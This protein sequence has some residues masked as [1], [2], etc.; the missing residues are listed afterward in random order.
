MV[1]KNKLG[2]SVFSPTGI[3]VVLVSIALMVTS[4][5]ILQRISVF[6]IIFNIPMLLLGI[7]YLMIG[8]ARVQIHWKR[9][10]IMVIGIITAQ[11]AILGILM[12]G[13]AGQ[14]ELMVLSV[15]FA[16]IGVALSIGALTWPA[17]RER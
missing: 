2:Y 4:I 17:K 16:F 10:S 13:M 9:I 6:W 12:W 7:A 11:V 14:D 5:F 15:V 3:I 8:L 1:R